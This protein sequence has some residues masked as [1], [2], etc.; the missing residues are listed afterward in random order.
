MPA[1]TPATPPAPLRSWGHAPLLG[2]FCL[3]VV[4]GSLS[5]YFRPLE[6]ATA[7]TQAPVP[8]PGPT[9]FSVIGESR[10][11]SSLAAATASAPDGAVIEISASGEIAAEPIRITGKQLTIQAAAGARCALVLSG[12]RAGAAP[13]LASDSALHLKQIELRSVRPVATAAG[14]AASPLVEASGPSFT[15]DRCA[16][17]DQR[18]GDC[19]LLAAMESRLSH[20]RCSSP[21]GTGI[22][23]R[24][25]RG[26]QLDVEHC[27]VESARSLVIEFA[28][29]P[30]GEAAPRA[31]LRNTTFAGDRAVESRL[32]PGAAEQTIVHAEEC[33]F[34]VR[35]LLAIVWLRPPPPAKSMTLDGMRQLL[36]KRVAWS[37][38]RCE[39]AASGSLLS[40]AGPRFELMP[41]PRRPRTIDDWERL[42]NHGPSGSVLRDFTRATGSAPLAPQHIG[43]DLSATGPG[44]E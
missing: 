37:D 26:K 41:L 25:A 21:A 18:G 43:A 36:L 17:I 19:L 9:R 16:F 11:Y 35:H 39:I 42:W 24:A 30:I 10:Q 2:A 34:D 27:W 22:A 13:L 7:P 38:H 6:P 15:A 28:A 33:R 40:A 23:W 29:S 31:V 14:T 5:W 12:S 8:A 44:S 1:A 32:D 4:V 3:A 20:C